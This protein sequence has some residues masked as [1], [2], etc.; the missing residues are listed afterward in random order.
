MKEQKYPVFRNP[1]KYMQCRVSHTP[2]GILKKK[3]ERATLDRCLAVT[4]GV[5]TICDVP[6][7]PGRLFPYWKHKDF[8]VHAVDVSEE[9]VNA[10]RRLY[11]QL[12]LEGSV[13][14]GDAFNLAQSLDEIPDLV[15]SIRFLYY[16]DREQRVDLLKAFADATQRYVLVQYKTTETLKGQKGLIRREEPRRKHHLKTRFASHEE[17]VDE[18][19]AAGLIPLRIDPVGEFSDRV[20][21]LAEKPQAEPAL[22]GASQ[23][24]QIR[25]VKPWQYKLLLA[26]LALFAVLYTIGFSE[27][28]FW[29]ENEA[30]YSL[31]ARSVMEGH[32]LVPLINHDLLSDKPPLMFWWVALISS[33]FGGVVEWTARLANVIP[34]LGVL[35]VIHSFARR[36]FGSWTALLGVIILGTSYEFWENAMGVSTDMM[37]LLLLTSAW[38]AMYGLFTAPFRWWRWLVL[39]GGL[40][41]A[42]LTKGPVA[43]VL[44]ALVGVTFSCWRFGFKGCWGGLMRLRPFSG[45]VLALAPFAAWIAAVYFAHGPDPLRIILFKHNFERFVDAFDHQKPWYYYFQEL[46]VNL[47]PWA[48]LIPFV[49]WYLFKKR[50][51]SLRTLWSGKTGAGA[52]PEEFRLSVVVYSLTVITVVFVFFSFSTSKRDYYL[53]PVMPWCAL[54]ISDW[55]WHKVSAPI[56]V[57]RK[58]QARQHEFGAAM[59]GTKWGRGFLKLLAVMILTMVGYALLRTELL[60]SQKSPEPFALAISRNVDDQEGLI[61]VDDEDPRV[62]YYLEERFSLADDDAAGM[63][64]IQSMLTSGDA[65]DLLVQAGDLDHFLNYSGPQ[66]YV[67]DVLSYREENVYHLTTK[68]EPGLAPL[69]GIDI[70]GISAMTYHEERGTLFVLGD[71]GRIA[72]VRLDGVI[73]HQQTIGGDLEGITRLPGTDQLFAVE[74]ESGNIIQIDARNLSATRTYP[75][76]NLSD[77]LEGTENAEVAIEGLAF[78]N[79]PEGVTLYAVNEDNPPL[80]MMLAL[81]NDGRSTPTAITSAVREV[82]REDL[83]EL[84]WDQKSSRLLAISNAN[85]QLIQLSTDGSIQA[86]WALP[87]DEQEAMTI[88]PDGRIVI[89]DENGFLRSHQIDA[90]ESL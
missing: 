88:L 59:L 46:P 82:D 54:L 32:W 21:V 24:P 43:P 33:I 5:R 39:W 52:H 2:L 17:I 70:P 50:V 74:E 23:L 26:V 83:T 18:I 25:V 44:T 89:C 63:N 1:E 8:R 47:L 61:I 76:R 42:L 90:L 38:C 16:F 15:A 84:A 19:Q 9:M 12:E 75:M 49:V 27:R 14:E 45:S 20:Y 71:G 67:E 65:T 10:S 37:L 60:D 68:N 66:L 81:V 78:A 34:S 56:D 28:S 55:I 58:H 79:Q 48:V 51:L 22:G 41:L 29:G 35:A 3:S 64:R 31:G 7:G 86:T 4:S 73:L 6:S 36:R 40:A 53:L 62:M 13:R 69:H 85:D 11:E 57:R 80:L 77:M 30:Y 87:G 72:E